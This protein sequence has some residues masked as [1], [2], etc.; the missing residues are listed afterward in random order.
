MESIHSCSQSG[1]DLYTD[2]LT[3][4]Y[5]NQRL[6]ALENQARKAEGDKYDDQAGQLQLHAPNMIRI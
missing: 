1:Q 4:D 2:F 6:K 5:I 3:P